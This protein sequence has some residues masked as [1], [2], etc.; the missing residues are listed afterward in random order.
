MCKL[1]MQ[2]VQTNKFI[3][4]RK[5]SLMDLRK[6]LSTSNRRII[7]YNVLMVGDIHLHQYSQS[8]NR[9]QWLKCWMYYFNFWCE[10]YY[11]M[12]SFWV[13]FRAF[14]DQLFKVVTLS[15]CFSFHVLYILRF[16]YYD[17]E[18]QHTH[19]LFCTRK[20]WDFELMGFEY[21]L[22]FQDQSSQKFKNST[23]KRAHR[24]MVYCIK[25]IK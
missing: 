2:S 3:L 7:N 23:T 14:V 5:I 4:R 21:T 19:I 18:H 12:L 22:V 9:L 20:R 13:G 1:L 25:L 16:L 24:C 10:R 8:E 11:S 15:S 17:N 6:I